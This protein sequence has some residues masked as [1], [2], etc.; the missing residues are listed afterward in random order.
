MLQASNILIDS[1][2]HLRLTD[3]G[4]AVLSHNCGKE[5]PSPER[6]CRGE[7]SDILKA[8][9]LGCQQVRVFHLPFPCCCQASVVYSITRVVHH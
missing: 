4:L 9:C 8:C 3:F 1:S 7:K 2:G 6:L 5:A